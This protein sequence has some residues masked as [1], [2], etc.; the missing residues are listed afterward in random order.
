MS[1]F[2]WMSDIHL[3][4]VEEGVFSELLQDIVQSDAEGIW[5]TGDIATGRDVCSWIRKIQLGTGLP[6]YFV[7]GNHDYYH[8]SLY[9]VNRKVAQLHDEMEDVHWMD[10]TS[11]QKISDRGDVL[12]GVGGWGD[13]RAGSFIDT[14][15]RINDHRLIEEFSNVSREILKERLQKKGQEMATLLHTKLVDCL[16]AECIWVLT[17]VPPFTEACW[18]KGKSGDPNW[19]P[20]FV[21]ISVGEVLE[22]FAEKN[23]SK[24]IRVLCGHGHNRGIVQKSPNLVVYTAAAEYGKPSVEVYWSL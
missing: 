13:A 6:V 21:C 7:L 14:P 8:S 23:P 12:I 1:T 20:D 22:E 15:I 17:H 4:M 19:T 16:D 24:K 5:L 3:D 9:D 10:R 11:I 2:A 18:Y